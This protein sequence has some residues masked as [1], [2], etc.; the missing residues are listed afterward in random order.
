MAMYLKGNTV[1]HAKLYAL[2]KQAGITGAARECIATKAADSSNIEGWKGIFFNLAD[3]ADSFDSGT[4]W[5]VVKAIGDNNPYRDSEYSD[6]ITY[7]VDTVD[8]SNKCMIKFN[9]D[10]YG[11]INID[12]V[13][14]RNNMTIRAL[15]N[16][17]T[18]IVADCDS[19]FKL[20]HLGNQTI[21]IPTMETGQWVKVEDGSNG[22]DIMSIRVPS[23][24]GVY[25]ITFDHS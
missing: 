13:N 23:N 10:G 18:T 22:H 17:T 4:N 11:D 12:Y 24:T 7:S 2:Y 1:I 15:E 5:L 6:Y 19:V 21:Y 8:L 3:Y 16:E 25:T 14:N 9:V 20:T